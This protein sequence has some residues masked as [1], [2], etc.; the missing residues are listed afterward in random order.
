TP[1]KSV[2]S[3]SSRSTGRTTVVSAPAAVS[4]SP[5]L[6]TGSKED[7][8]ITKICTAPMPVRVRVPDHMIKADDDDPPAGATG[9]PVDQPRPGAPGAAWREPELLRRSGSPHR[10]C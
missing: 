10:V 4:H 6:P 5:R 9:F 3:G 8:S 2:G 1:W 7:S